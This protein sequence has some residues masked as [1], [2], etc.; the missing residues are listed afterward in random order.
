VLE[1]G[2]HSSHVGRYQFHSPRSFIVAGSNTARTIAASIR[3]AAASPIPISFMSM[4]GI[5]ANTAQNEK[6]RDSGF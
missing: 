4:I 3:T 6:Q 1:R 5:S 2:R